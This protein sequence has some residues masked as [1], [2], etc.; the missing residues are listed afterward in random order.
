MIGTGANLAGSCAR[1]GAVNS[2]TIRNATIVDEAGKQIHYRLESNHRHTKLQLFNETCLVSNLVG[3][4]SPF[5]RFPMIC[6]HAD[7]APA[8][9]AI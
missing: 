8:D 7:R 5:L 4:F 2:G 9:L 1:N 6:P 3:L